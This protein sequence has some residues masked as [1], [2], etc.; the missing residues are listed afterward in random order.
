MSIDPAIIL[1]PNGP[2]KIG[3]NGH[4]KVTREDWLNSAR[5]ILVSEG[6][7]AV[8]IL[9]L[10]AR[11]GV[12]RSSFYWYFKDRDEV[13]QELLDEWESRNTRTVV[14]H[15]DMPAKNI[16]EGLCNFFR[17]FIGP[18]VFDQGTDFAIREWSRRDASVR[19]KVDAADRTRIAAVTNLFIRFDFTA[20]EADARARIVYFM[21]LGY[22]ALEVR[23]SMKTRM[24]RVG[25]YVQGFTSQTPDADAIAEFSEYAYAVAKT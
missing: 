1:R 6:A 3:P 12:S 5:E 9:T 22:H 16:T 17:C 10:S 21:Q 20:I 7:T 8:K 24:S 2:S 23:E 13:M 18:D 15:C 14:D 4:T 11:L 19:R 25:P